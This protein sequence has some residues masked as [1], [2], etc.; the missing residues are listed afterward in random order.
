MA[1][2]NVHLKWF[3]TGLDDYLAKNKLKQTKQRR[4][5]IEYFLGMK[6]HVDA[7]ELYEIARR[8]GSNVGLA[9]IYRTLNLLKDAGLVDQNSFVNGRA[10]YEIAE[11]GQHHDHLICTSCGKVIE[12]ANDKIEDLQLEVAKS[13][14]FQL[15]S[16]RLD[17]FGLCPHCQN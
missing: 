11:P 3:W 12:F 13:L 9:T 14:G 15:S 4:L 16:H 1:D 6:N 8:K 7:E 5:I 2:K 17:L 10:V